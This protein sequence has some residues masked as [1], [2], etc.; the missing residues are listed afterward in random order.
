MASNLLSEAAR[1]ASLTLFALGGSGAR[2]LEPMLHLCALGLGPRQLK[3]IIVDPDQSNAAVQRSRGL[4]ERYIEIRRHL[5]RDALPEDGYFRTEVIDVIGRKILWS[6]I[7]DDDHSQDGRFSVRIARDLM[8]GAK[9][10][11]LGLL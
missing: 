6:P 1:K 8:S 3:V 10:Q 5:E 2:A 7:A 9:G 11:K 4:M